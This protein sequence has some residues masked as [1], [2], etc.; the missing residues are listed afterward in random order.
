MTREEKSR[1]LYE[2]LMPLLKAGKTVEIHPYGSSMFPLIVSLS[3]SVFLCAPNDV[4]LKKGDILLYQREN[5]LLVLHRLCRICKDGYYFT[6]DNQTAVEG[7]LQRTQVLAVVTHICRKGRT[8]SVKHPVYRLLSNIWLTLRPVRPFISRP[9]GM[10][11][12]MLRRKR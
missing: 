1:R 7:P 3:D 11:W 6:G 10:L 4:P 8:F 5:G 2:E 12:R 9:I